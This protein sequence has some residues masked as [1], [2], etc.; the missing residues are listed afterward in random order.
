VRYGDPMPPRWRRT[1]VDL[2]AEL[3]RLREAAGRTAAEVAAG[4]GWAES[5]L[6]RKENGQIGISDVDLTRFLDL[7]QVSGDDRTQLLEIADRP[8]SPRL[9]R[10]R[11]KRSGALPLAYE[12]YV[13][14]EEQAA[15]ISIYSTMVVPSLIQ[16]PEYAAAI[17]QSTPVPED[18]YVRPRI[19]T[20][21]GRQAVLGRQPS[22]RLRVVLD[23]SVLLRKIGDRDT[24]RRQMLRLAE[25]SERPNTMIQVITLDHG[26]HP[27]LAG[28]FTMLEFDDGSKPPQVFSDGL[29]GGVLRADPEDV[30]RYRA[31]FDMLAGSAL[32]RRR[33]LELF[34]V[35]A[36]RKPIE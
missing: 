33:S 16:I 1:H 15:D 3:R 5:T 30:K 28:S 20:R 35:T 29:T 4:L 10:P 25:A 14:L 22:P 31:C 8:R 6:S 36:N 23:E 18:E 11:R 2:G 26:A 21:I 34:Q 7:L 19:T 24:M 17:I 32:D 27:G 13:A 9:P 12:K